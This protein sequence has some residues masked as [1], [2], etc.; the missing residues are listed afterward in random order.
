MTSELSY[1][2][3]PINPETTFFILYG[4]TLSGYYGVSFIYDGIKDYSTL[5]KIKNASIALQG[6]AQ[7]S[8][9][10]E[11]LTYFPYIYKRLERVSYTYFHPF[12]LL[13]GNQRHEIIE[14][15]K[16]K[17]VDLPQKGLKNP[18]YHFL[19]NPKGSIES[20][21]NQTEISV[22]GQLK[23]KDIKP[24]IISPL[25]IPALKGHY[26]FSMKMSFIAG[27]VYC[28]AACVLGRIFYR[29]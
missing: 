23:G 27:S 21:M 26:S 5:N 20:L 25:S 28:V 17:W 1:R 14:P 15:E 3:K 16:A 11:P 29:S 18:D 19:L 24:Y 13:V 6:I 10:K 8:E 7:T 4:A 9:L 2:S 12:T 22:I